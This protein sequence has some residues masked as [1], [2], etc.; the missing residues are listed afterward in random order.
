[1]PA[2]GRRPCAAAS[3]SSQ[4]R[5]IARFAAALRAPASRPGRDPADRTAAASSALA[6]TRTEPT[7]T[8]ESR[9]GAAVPPPRMAAQAAT[10]NESAATS[11]TTARKDTR[12]ESARG[13]IS[14]WGANLILHAMWGLGHACAAEL[15]AGGSGG[16]EIG[17]AG[18][19]RPSITRSGSL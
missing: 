6:A 9:L 4:S 3:P 18:S 19:V 11:D 8:G 12:T 16:C 15:T 10:A 13:A 14:S 1:M 7:V 5:S 2:A 17:P